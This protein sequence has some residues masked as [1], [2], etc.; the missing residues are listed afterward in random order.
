[1]DTY[2]EIS[3]EG[4]ER[5]SEG[6]H[7]RSGGVVTG[8]EPG[9]QAAQLEAAEEEVA[10]EDADADGEYDESGTF[11]ADEVHEHVAVEEGGDYTEHAE[12]PDDEDEFGQD[13]PVE[14]GG[15]TKDAA[16]PHIGAADDTPELP[17]DENDF[18]RDVPVGVVGQHEG[19]FKPSTPLILVTHCR[20]R[21]TIRQYRFA[22]QSIY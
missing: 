1:M 17:Q 15:E 18:E 20:C 4:G 11:D 19:M 5:L 8:V 7:V 13:L 14:V 16:Y 9:F 22:H 21:T 12:F 2:E 6:D 3:G 10:D